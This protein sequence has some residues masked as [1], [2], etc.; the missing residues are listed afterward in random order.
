M[1]SRIAYRARLDACNRMSEPALAVVQL[2]RVCQ[3]WDP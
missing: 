2:E 1:A 3:T